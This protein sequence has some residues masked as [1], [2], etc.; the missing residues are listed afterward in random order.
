M[1]PAF[2]IT[3]PYEV[4][5]KPPFD[6]KKDF[7][8]IVLEEFKKPEPKMVTEELVSGMIKEAL[9]LLPKVPNKIIEKVIEKEIRI[10]PKKE[11]KTYAEEKLVQELKNQIEELKKEVQASKKYPMQDWGF[12]TGKI[13]PNTSNQEGKFLTNSGNKLLWATVTGSSSG[14]DPFYIGDPDTDGSWR[15]TIVGDNLSVQRRESG[16]YVEKAAFNP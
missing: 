16:S 10:E 11:T 9:S 1:K 15:F 12:R 3:K 4:L 6:P 13:I 2:D 8:A 7:K 5:D 14:S